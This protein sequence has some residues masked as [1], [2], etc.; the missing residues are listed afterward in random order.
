MDN[1]CSDELYFYLDGS[2]K[3]QNFRFLEVENPHQLH[4]S[5]KLTKPSLKLTKPSL[6]L[7]KPNLKLIRPS[8]KLTKPSLKVIKPSLKLTVLRN[9]TLFL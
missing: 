5:E 8:L 4:Q 2:V 1:F 7:T 6:K 3:K 9:W